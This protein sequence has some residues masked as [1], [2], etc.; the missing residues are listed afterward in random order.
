MG[1]GHN[2]RITSGLG[3]NATIGFYN[4]IPICVSR[5]DRN[6][7]MFIDILY[8]VQNTFTVLFYSRRPSEKYLGHL[9]S[10]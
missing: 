9:I 2:G 1:R 6:N 5:S 4:W 7:K 10:S 3:K 8:N